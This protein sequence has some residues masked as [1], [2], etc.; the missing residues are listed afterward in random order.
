MREFLFPGAR[1]GL[2]PSP[3][4]VGTHAA[5]ESRESDRWERVPIRSPNHSIM[6]N[7]LASENGAKL[8]GENRFDV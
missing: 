6:I 1:A 5:G 3:H 4:H 7:A 8:P 2:K